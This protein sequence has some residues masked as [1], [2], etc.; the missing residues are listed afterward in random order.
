MLVPE[1]E[2]IKDDLREAIIRRHPK[3]RNFSSGSMLDIIDEIIAIQIKH[4]D[5]NS[6]RRRP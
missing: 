2:D 5:I 1:I 4:F 6:R 3:I